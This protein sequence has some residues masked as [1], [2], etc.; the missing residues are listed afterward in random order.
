MFFI[1]C[2]NGVACELG[3][4][5]IPGSNCAEGYDGFMCAECQD[6][7]WTNLGTYFCHPC[8]A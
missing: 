7:Y 4:D 6:Y 3:E 5:A 1:R 2:F 8:S